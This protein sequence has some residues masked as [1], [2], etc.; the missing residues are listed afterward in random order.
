MKRSTPKLTCPWRK[1]MIERFS[2]LG[3]ELKVLDTGGHLNMFAMFDLLTDQERSV[4]AYRFT[5]ALGPIAQTQREVGEKMGVCSSR[6]S[7]IE[8]KATR[9][10]RH[11]RS[12]NAFR[13]IAPWQQWQQPSQITLI[14]QRKLRES[15]ERK[16]S[17]NLR[18]WEEA[19]RE[20]AW[21][22]LMKEKAELL[23]VRAQLKKE[24][25]EFIA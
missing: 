10:L 25:E 7:A 1:E 9:M 5:T 23:V 14:E 3:E 11:E 18:K 15:K 24:W 13:R 2:E 20:R 21:A 8:S 16:R 17:E 6:I 12:L 19:K 4:I 22:D